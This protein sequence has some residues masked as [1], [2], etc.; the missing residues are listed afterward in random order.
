MTPYNEKGYPVPSTVTTSSS[1]PATPRA[2]TSSPNTTNRRF[3]RII[4]F[5]LV[6]DAYA[7]RRH[8]RQL[9]HTTVREHVH[10]EQIAPVVGIDNASLE[11]HVHPPQFDGPLHG[12]I[13]PMVGG[14]LGIVGLFVDD[15]PSA[16]NIRCLF[17]VV[18]QCKS[19]ESDRA[20]EG[21]A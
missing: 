20:A 17:D 6:F 4:R 3:V 21:K 9:I 19:I 1:Q 13:E 18:D 10:V 8:K 15:A 5:S 16:W 11:G 7:E 2:A 12:H 14:Q